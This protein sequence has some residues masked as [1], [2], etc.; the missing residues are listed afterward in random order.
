MKPMQAALKGAREIGFTILSITFSLVAVF[1]PILFMGGIVGRIFH[2][3]AVTISVAILV[4]GFVSL[5]L[6]PMLCSRFLKQGEHDEKRWAKKLEKAFEWLLNHYESSLK[7]VLRHRSFMLIVTFATIALSIVAFII[8][9]KGFFPLEDTGFIFGQT[10][11]SQDI[12]YD[13]MVAKQA[14]LAKKIA[15]NPAV[16]NVFYAVGG[17][18][19]A[20]NSGRVFISLKALSDRKSIFEVINELRSSA[21]QIEGINVFMQP[22]QNMQVGGRLSKSLYQ[23]TLQSSNLKDLYLWSEKLTNELSTTKGFQDV[24]T[25][26]QLKSLQAIITVD[27]GKAASLGVT[28][29]AI[30]QALYAAFGTAQVASLYTS[31][32]DYAVIMEVSDQ[33]Q[34]S[35]EDIGKIYIKGQGD[36]LVS[37][38]SIATITRAAGPLSV[39][40]QGQLPAVTISFNLEKGM[41]LGSAV[42]IINST[43]QKMGMPE[44]ISGSFQGAAQIFQQSAS[45]QGMLILVTIIVI[46]I[47]LGMLYESFIHPITILS[48][49][50]SAAIGATISLMLVGMDL[51][52]IAIVGV[53]LLI[54]IVKKNAIMMIDFA[55]TARNSG[56]TAEESIYQACVLR[57][58]PIVMTSMAA[59]CGSLPIAFGIG[60]GSEL[61]QPLGVTIVGGLLTSQ[62]LTL[63]I[64]PVIYL[65][66]E[67]FRKNIQ[68]DPE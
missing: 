67:R 58:R 27:Q 16:A 26:L 22:V 24:T 3:F 28:Y 43:Q 50:P 35:P 44:S 4:S 54:G 20:L 42:D 14:E 63:Y 37:L 66:L 64:T 6:T 57:F 68:K 61:R 52:I 21:S 62:L 12:S 30:R 46:Y 59:I 18:R 41:S 53:V 23:Y 5:T 8:V 34:R 17:N 45:G 56:M 38:E 32:N 7:W 60:A 31:S 65:Y 55:V 19:G 51:S 47:I 25:D 15:Q 39:N 49:L 11:A 13:A 1:I 2:E 48:G 29:D 40:H 33:Y 36:K 9:P 10:E